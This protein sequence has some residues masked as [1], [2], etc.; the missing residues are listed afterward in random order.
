MGH[1]P[2]GHLSNAVHTFAVYDRYIDDPLPKKIQ[3][4]KD[5]PKIHV[6]NHLGRYFEENL[7]KR[8]VDELV[9][10]HVF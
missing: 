2:L 8:L 4:T 6:L 10:R 3:E 7:Q 9:V 1:A 5:R